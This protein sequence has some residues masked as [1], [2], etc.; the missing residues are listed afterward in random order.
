VIAGLKEF[1]V[2]CVLLAPTGR[3]AKVLSM[4][5]GMSAYTVHKQI[6]RQ[7]S[8]GENGFGS[9]S[10]SPNKLKDALFIV[11]E[12]SL[13]GIDGGSQQTNVQFGTGNLLEDLVAYV[14]NGLGCRLILI[15]D[16]AQLPPVGHE[17]SPALSHEYMD[18]F[19][20]VSWAEL[21]T[22]VRQQKDSGILYNA[23]ILRTVIAE[24]YES[25]GALFPIENLELS[26]DG[27]TDIQRI[28]G[29]ELIEALTDAYDRYG[30]DETIVLSR[31][32][33]RANRYNAG[34][35]SQ[36]Q[37]KEE[38][39]VRGDKLM[40]VKNCYQFIENMKDM[41]Y[42]AN[43]DIV[44]LLSI[45]HYEDRY[46]LHFAQ[47]RLSFPDYNDQEISAKVCL[48]TL[49]SESA[50]LTY[51]QQNAL[52]QGV[53]ADYAHLTT[54]KK[55]YDAVRED[56]FYNALQ[57]KYANAITCHKS[58]G[59]QW[60]CVF[61]DNPFWQEFFTADDYKWL[62]TAITRA[63]EKVYLVNFKDDYFL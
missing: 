16:S 54:K 39:L 34:I 63:V 27:F 20:G 57:L 61:I 56:L 45:N 21:T 29:G 17:Y 52:Y 59:G 41:D 18:H 28:N 15:G 38:R 58:Q 46:G 53:L 6:Y 4:Y 43:G 32:N 42:I 13:I 50:S 3:A 9:F 24:D 49:E 40:V 30:E 22:V 48:D 35:R 33:K 51:E 14:R 11:D 60:R 31:S 44:N 47:A 25:G 7:K 62:Y 19:G 37:Y 5:S 23:T 8:V 10:L 26:T 36:I 1:E 55:R 12:V 2:P